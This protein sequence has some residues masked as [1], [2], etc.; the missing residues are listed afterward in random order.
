MPLTDEQE[1]RLASLLEGL[2][3]EIKNLYPAAKDFVSDMV[4]RHDQYGQDTRVSPKQWDWLTKL[5]KEFVSSELP[6]GDGD[7]RRDEDMDDQA[8]F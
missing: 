6:E 3:P 4:K 1:T 2:E 7:P 5:Y 8:P